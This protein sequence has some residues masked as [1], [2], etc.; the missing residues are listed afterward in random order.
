MLPCDWLISNL[1]YQAIEQVYQITECVY[2][3]IYSA[4]NMFNWKYSIYMI[5]LHTHLDLSLRTRFAADGSDHFSAVRH[6]FIITDA[7]E[8]FMPRPHI[9]VIMVA[10]LLHILK[11]HNIIPREKKREREGGGGNDMGE[12][13]KKSKSV[14]ISSSVLLKPRD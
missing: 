9:N 10:Q 6:E 3:Y 8:T 1:C 7:Q 5:T 4:L 11:I 13:N 2:I 12:C 14:I